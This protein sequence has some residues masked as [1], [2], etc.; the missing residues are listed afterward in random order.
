MCITVALV[1]INV[2]GNLLFIRMSINSLH[3]R[4]MCSCEHFIA[5]PVPFP[6]LRWETPWAIHWRRNDVPLRPG[7]QPRLQSWGSTSL[8]YGITTL[9]QNKIRQ[10]YPV[11]CSRL[12]N[13]TVFIKKLRK[14]LGVRPIFFREIRTPRPPVVAPIL[15]HYSTLQSAQNA[16]ARLITGVRRCEH[17]T[18]VL[19]TSPPT[20]GIQVD[21]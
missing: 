1:R 9:L 16:A 5:F 11:W 4:F 14:N 8:V 3:N 7:A 15:F 20:S 12:H 17:I 19:A 18:P 6:H 21:F 10:V 2:F 13:Q